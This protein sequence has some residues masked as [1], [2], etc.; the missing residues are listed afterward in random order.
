MITAMDPIEDKSTS[1]DGDCKEED[2][3]NESPSLESCNSDSEYGSKNNYK[4]RH[5]DED[6][7][8]QPIIEGYNGTEIWN[9]CKGTSI[10]FLTSPVLS[11][12][13]LV[14]MYS[15]SLPLY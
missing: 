1:T 15:P 6:Q 10:R 12:S 4:V 3:Y 13:T 8:L 5:E 7:D 2:N 11:H 9:D 14:H